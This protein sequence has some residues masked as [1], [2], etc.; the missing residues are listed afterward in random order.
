MAIALP[1]YLTDFE[2]FQ[3]EVLPRMEAAG[4]RKKFVLPE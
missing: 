3:E 1:S 2:V 4:L